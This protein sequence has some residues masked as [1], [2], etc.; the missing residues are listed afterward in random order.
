MLTTIKLVASMEAVSVKTYPTY[1]LENITNVYLI[2][3][4]S[5]SSQLLVQHLQQTFAINCTLNGPDQ[6]PKKM[7]EHDL[8][9]LNHADLPQSLQIEHISSLNIHS[10][11]TPLAI[12][13]ICRESPVYKQIEWPNI[14]GIF[15]SDDTS[16][17][18]LKGI[19]AIDLG[20]L[21][22]P[23]IY[24]EYLASKRKP[25]IEKQKSDITLTQREHEIIGLLLLGR[26]NQEIANE[27]FLS[28]HTVK[29]HIYKLYKKINVKNRV[30][31]LHWAQNT[32][33]IQ[34]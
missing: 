3:N 15:H 30:Q 11:N 18:M 28:A 6:L 34:Q 14:K 16:E 22:I 20:G 12:I 29:T 8:V 7:S 21:W 9:L 23:R 1:K 24:T 17:I 19:R 33:D 25:P 13:N 2:C 31:A 4:G 26:S 5:L 27:L 10:K 32:L